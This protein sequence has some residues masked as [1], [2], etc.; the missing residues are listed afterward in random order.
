MTTNKSRE[1]EKGRMKQ[2]QREGKERK[3]KRKI[4]KYKGKKKPKSL[5]KKENA[6]LI[7]DK[8]RFPLKTAN[9]TISID[10]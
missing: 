4:R 6:A 9:W 1:V 3:G 2:S 5:W 8:F 10:K 7:R